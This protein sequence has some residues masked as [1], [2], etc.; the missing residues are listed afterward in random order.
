MMVALLEPKPARQPA[1]ALPQPPLLSI[2]IP[3]RDEAHRIGGLL[4]R[5][6]RDLEARG[7]S[8]EVIVVDDGSRDATATIAEGH[9][10]LFDALRVLR[11]NETNGKGAAVRAGWSDARGGLVLTMDVGSTAP[12]QALDRLEDFIRRGFDVV[13]GARAWRNG[14]RTMGARVASF[15]ARGLATVAATLVPT[16]IRDTQTGCKLVRGSTARDLARRSEIDGRAFDVEVLALARKL[17]LRI[18]EVEVPAPL[19]R[20]PSAR[21]LAQAPRTVADLL[22]IRRRLVHRRSD[23]VPSPHRRSRR[24]PDET[25]EFTQSEA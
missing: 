14:A 9:A 17:G 7:R 1:I 25:G 12:L 18:A 4:L 13:V 15:A 16:G 19:P 24:R 20:R 8:A 22:R 2:V 21:E 11:S 6:A 3:A 10:E 23:P 5:I